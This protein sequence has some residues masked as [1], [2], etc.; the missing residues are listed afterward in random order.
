MAAPGAQASTP[1]TMSTA[2]RAGRSRSSGT[3]ERLLDEAEAL[4]ARSSVA[5]VTTREITEAAGQRNTSAVSYH[6][7]SREGLLLAILSRRGAPV[8]AERGR[9]R[10][11]FGA[12]PT[13]AELV[14]CLV[15]PY[16]EMLASVPGRSYLR[17]VAQLR[18]RFAAWRV[19]SDS[20]T[21]EHLARVLDEIEARPDASAAVRR[22]RVVA[23]IMVMTATTAERARRIDEGSVPE[24]DHEAF[25]SNLVDMCAALVMG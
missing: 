22:E 8:D 5:G 19:E 1:S 18:G 24:L 4:F 7:G 11:E 23:L 3:R 16:S 14:T 6:F 21:T 20:E 17:I 2:P 25:V 9:L 10:A 13:L 12:A 15:V